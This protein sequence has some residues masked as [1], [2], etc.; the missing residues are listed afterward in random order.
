VSLHADGGA[1]KI[2]LAEPVPAG[3]Q[4][5]VRLSYEGRIDPDTWLTNVL[6]PEWVGLKPVAPGHRSP[7]LSQRRAPSGGPKDCGAE[8][9]RSNPGGV[10][11]RVTTGVG[12][13]EAAI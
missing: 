3:R 6:T 10:M 13:A 5:V 9:S 1:T 4:V 7:P 11:R 8:G 12:A 2:E